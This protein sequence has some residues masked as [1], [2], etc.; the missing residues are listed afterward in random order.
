MVAVSLQYTI[1][2]CAVFILRVCFVCT[3]HCACVHSLCLRLAGRR[4]IGGDVC[5]G[6]DTATG[7]RDSFRGIGGW[8]LLWEVVKLAEAG[9]YTPHSALGRKVRDSDLNGLAPEHHPPSVRRTSWGL[10]D[11]GYGRQ[12]RYLFLALATRSAHIGASVIHRALRRAN[13]IG[14]L[15]LRHPGAFFLPPRVHGTGRGWTRELD[16]TGQQQEAGH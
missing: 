6:Y 16:C 8:G 15:R 4:A 13:G 10:R 11:T 14:G 12:A 2:S 3:R 9:T 5:L 1:P 7:F